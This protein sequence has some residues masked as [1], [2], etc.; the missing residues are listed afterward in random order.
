MLSGHAD[1]PHSLM[2]ERAPPIQL[3]DAGHS[4]PSQPALEPEGH[5]EERIVR[6]GEPLHGVEVEVMVGPGFPGPAPLRRAT[7][8]LATR[9]ASKLR[10]SNVLAQ[11]RLSKNRVRVQPSGRRNSGLVLRKPP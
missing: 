7:P 2:L 10:E 1:H 5:H 8:S 11:A 9:G 6:C 3:L 4:L